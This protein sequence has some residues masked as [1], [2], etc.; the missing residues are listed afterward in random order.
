M[1]NSGIQC[2]FGIAKQE[3]SFDKVLYKKFVTIPK[4]HFDSSA[5][6]YGIPRGGTAPCIEE[7]IVHRLYGKSAQK[8]DSKRAH[9]SVF[10]KRKQ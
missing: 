1:Q 10:A 6:P 5:Q 9:T 2:Y 3:E 4:K 7:C 8:E